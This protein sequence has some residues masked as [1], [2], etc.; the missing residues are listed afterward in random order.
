MVHI[1]RRRKRISASHIRQYQVPKEPA[2]LRRTWRLVLKGSKI[3]F[4]YTTNGPQL[5]NFGSGTHNLDS[6]LGVN[7]DSGIFIVGKLGRCGIGFPS[8]LVRDQRFGHK[9]PKRASFTEEAMLVNGHDYGVNCFALERPPDHSSVSNCKLGQ[10]TARKNTTLRDIKSIHD[11][12]DI[13]TSGTSTFNVLKEFAGDQVVHVLAKVRRVE[14]YPA[15]EVI[16]E[17]HGGRQYEGQ[18]E[19]SKEIDL[20]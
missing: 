15:L 5:A 2:W 1:F 10:A 16:K 4:L 13:V 19:V 6:D 8:D 18:D 14:G 9:Y 12:Y 11:G 3:V 17:E 20:K 7:L